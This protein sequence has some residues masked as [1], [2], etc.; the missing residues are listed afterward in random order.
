MIGVR[1]SVASLLA[2]VLAAGAACVQAQQIYRW[3]DDKGRVHLTDTPPP[4]SA[5]GVQ[6]PKP[7]VPT[8]GASARSSS[9]SSWRRR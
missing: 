1:P 4:A 3:T 7:A 5:K 8:E 6:K 9:P 2:A